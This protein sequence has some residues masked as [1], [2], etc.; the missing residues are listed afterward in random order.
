MKTNK[1]KLY[2]ILINVVILAFSVI[3]AFLLE[4]KHPIKTDEGL[5]IFIITQAIVNLCFVV[6]IA[7]LAFSRKDISHQVITYS[8][9]ILIQLLPLL[10]RLFVKGDKPSTIFAVII[11]FVVMI[12]YLGIVLSMGVLGD[13]MKK[14]ET[15]LVGREIKVQD[16]DDYND[17]TGK[18]VGANN[19]KGQK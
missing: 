8:S 7:Y 19:K 4:D 13:K 5:T 2:F 14:A 9:T 18:F 11:I 1:S 6:V 17:E 15:E 3:I 10:I 12:I 16:V